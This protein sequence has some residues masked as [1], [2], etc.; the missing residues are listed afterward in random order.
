[1]FRFILHVSIVLAAIFATHVEA[2]STMIKVS[3]WTEEYNSFFLPRGIGSVVSLDTKDGI[4]CISSITT[5]NKFTIKCDN[6][7]GKRIIYYQENTPEL[8]A[9]IMSNGTILKVEDI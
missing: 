5:G 2:K 7:D 8:G 9:T 1:M 6:K 4:S 3:L